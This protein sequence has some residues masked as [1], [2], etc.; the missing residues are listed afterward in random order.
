[1]CMLKE[2]INAIERH[3]VSGLELVTIAC[4]LGSE[5]NAMTKGEG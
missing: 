5:K 3:V 1:M 2:K 4:L